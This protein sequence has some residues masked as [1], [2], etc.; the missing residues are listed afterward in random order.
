MD[1]AVVL[2]PMQWASLPNIEDVPQITDADYN[3]LR[4]VRSVLER[5]NAIGRFGINLLHRH[6]ELNPD[7]ILVEYTDEKN[8][9][10][11]SRVELIGD[12]E[13]GEGRIETNWV[14]E[15]ERASVACVGVC[16]YNQGHRRQHG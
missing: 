6:F 1:Q 14:F 2:K 15:R 11:T 7:E 5:H 3:V 10:L 12:S 9:T 8:R 16:V 4:E 13:V